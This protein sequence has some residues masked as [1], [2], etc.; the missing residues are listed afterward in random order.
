MPA[1]L[2]RTQPPP[3]APPLHGSCTF[4]LPGRRG[5]HA[6][7]RRTTRFCSRWRSATRGAGP[8]FRACFITPYRSWYYRTWGR[9]GSGSTPTCPA[10]R[11]LSLEGS[12][13]VPVARG[14]DDLASLPAGGGIGGAVSRR[15]RSPPQPFSGRP[16]SIGDLSSCGGSL[17]G[18]ACFCWCGA[19]RPV[20][21][22]VLGPFVSCS[23]W[24]SG[25]TRCS[26]RRWPGLPQDC[27]PHPRRSTVSH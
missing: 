15:D 22:G 6:W 20:R 14:D 1:R 24:V 16:Y 25:K 4:C 9:S 8:R 17:R 23:A 18:A 5:S 19:T 3:L 2:S 7:G 26:D 21:R 12:G 11:A 13:S 27:W 10:A